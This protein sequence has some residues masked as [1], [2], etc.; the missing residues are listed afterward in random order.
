M[1]QRLHSHF[2]VTFMSLKKVGTWVRATIGLPSWIF[3]YTFTAGMQKISNS[4]L[5]KHLSNSAFDAGGMAP[6][7]WVFFRAIFGPVASSHG[8]VIYFTDQPIAQCLNKVSV[9]HCR[10]VDLH[11]MVLAFLG[12]RMMRRG[13]TCL[14]NISINKIAIL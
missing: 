10:A 5:R 12:M 8:L 9:K 14:F 4:P 2:H 6:A 1:K 13:W 3:L 7:S 11:Y